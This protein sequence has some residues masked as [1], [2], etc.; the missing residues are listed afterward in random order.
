MLNL[1]KHISELLYRYD[2][3][4]VPNLGGFVANNVSARINEK[5]GIFSPPAREIGFN[6]SLSH[7][8]GLLINYIAK[9]EAITYETCQDMLKKHISVLKFQMSKGE[10]LI[11]DTVGNLKVDALGNTIFISNTEESFSLDSFGMGTFHFNTLEE[12]REQ[13]DKSQRF[14]RRALQSKSVKQIAASVAL[15]L[16][17]WMVSPEEVSNSKHSSFSDV[18]PRFTTSLNEKTR[19]SIVLVNM[20]VKFDVQAE[21]LNGN[22]VEI[23]EEEIVRN[24]FFVIGGSFDE[25]RPAD[26]YIK[27]LRSK[28]ILDAEIL[29][30]AKGRFRVSLA[31]F[32]EKDEAV[33][34]LKLF[35]QKNGFNSAWLLSQK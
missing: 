18:L 22:E 5:T 31:G 33:T 10:E 28:G 29:T 23:V 30:S 16:G 17:L 1:E 32:A 20:P 9:S 2:C 21:E 7:N 34:A 3:V 27:K 15:V 25:K 26:V 35:R 19:E 12:E 13:K 24:S 11:I 4:I 6:K 8:D 14:V